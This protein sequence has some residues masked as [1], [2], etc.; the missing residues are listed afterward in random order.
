TWALTLIPWGILAALRMR[1]WR[2]AALMIGVLLA[3]V[4]LSVLSEYLL[5]PYPRLITT[6]AQHVREFVKETPYEKW[7]DLDHNLPSLEFKESVGNG[8]FLF[9]NK[10]GRIIEVAPKFE[11]LFLTG[12]TALGIFL[13]PASRRACAFAS[14]NLLLIGLPLL[15]FYIGEMQRFIG[16]HVLL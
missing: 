6:F 5:S 3:V 8:W 14:I 7:R 16:P 12:I 11:E 15:I 13:V 1:W 10:S 4:G 9:F 2:G